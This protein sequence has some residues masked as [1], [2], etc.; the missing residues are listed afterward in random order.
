MKNYYYPQTL[1]QYCIAVC[2]VFNDLKVYRRDT[3]GNIV[4]E[5][6]VPVTFGPV[7]KTHQYRKEEESGKQYYLSVPRIAITY[8]GS[9]F[10][11]ERAKSQN[12]P[13]LHFGDTS[14]SVF[15]D[16]EPIPRDYMFT[17]DIRTEMMSDY[18][19]II[20]NIVPYFTPTKNIRV[21]E[22]S[23]LNL[24]RDV[25]LEITAEQF[26]YEKSLTDQNMREVN[27]S[28]SLLAKGYCYKPTSVGKLI[29]QIDVKYFIT[30]DIGEVIT[31][32]IIGYSTSAEMPNSSA[33]SSSGINNNEIFY[34]IR[35]EENL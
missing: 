26:T 15:T 31:Q 34:T 17:L 29:K 5:I 35:D 13:R 16:F 32:Q 11:A 8:E 20:E 24:E 33:Y 4:K 21:K 6:S 1:E 12:V 9:S 22:F 28:F 23:F 10:S 25:P 14:A 2:D 3:S 7:E 30:P 27:G 18:A 19:Q